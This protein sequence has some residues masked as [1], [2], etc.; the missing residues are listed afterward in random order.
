[1]RQR[2]SPHRIFWQKPHYHRVTYFQVLEVIEIKER[3]EGN[4]VC[5]HGAGAQLSASFNK[6]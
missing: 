2:I 6:T 4:N 5:P 3:C 1:M